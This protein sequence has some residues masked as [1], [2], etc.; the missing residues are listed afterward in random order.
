MAPPQWVSETVVGF[1]QVKLRTP[2]DP[3]LDTFAYRLASKDV[4]TDNEKVDPADVL[5]WRSLY[6]VCM[7]DGPE[8]GELRAHQTWLSIVIGRLVN[9][10]N[11][12]EETGNFE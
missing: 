6:E 5:D 12:P 7:N 2:D 10:V 1:A 9:A 11:P 8:A 4:F 3:C